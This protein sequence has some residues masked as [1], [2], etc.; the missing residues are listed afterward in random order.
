MEKTTRSLLKG[1]S[2]TEQERKQAKIARLKWLQKQYFKMGANAD[3]KEK[4][5][6]GLRAMECQIQQDRLQRGCR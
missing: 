3:Q 5:H 4:A 6:L 2:M 1:Y